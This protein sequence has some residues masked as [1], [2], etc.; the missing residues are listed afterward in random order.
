MDGIDSVAA[1]GVEDAVDVE[2]AFGGRR[3]AD[4]GGFVGKAHV[5]GGAIGIGVDRDAGDAEFL[6]ARD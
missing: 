5:Q 1:R 6:A 3:G 2:I 4:V